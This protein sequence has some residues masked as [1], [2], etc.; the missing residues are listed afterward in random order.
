MGLANTLSDPLAGIQV[1]T[2]EDQWRAAKNWTVHVLEREGV[3]K[4]WDVDT[5]PEHVLDMIDAD[6]HAMGLVFVEAC[7]EAVLERIDQLN[8]AE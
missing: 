7:P 4:P 3:E 2:L 1:V 8:G 5:I 6:L